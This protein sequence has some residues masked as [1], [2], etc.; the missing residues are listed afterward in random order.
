MKIIL[1]HLFFIMIILLVVHSCGTY[2]VPIGG[3]YN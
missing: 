3:V 2:E 1:K